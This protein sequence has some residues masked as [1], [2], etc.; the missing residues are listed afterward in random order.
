LELVKAPAVPLLSPKEKMPFQ[1]TPL[2]E[3]LIRVG[4]DDEKQQSANGGGY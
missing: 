4:P 1:V 3:R 2:F